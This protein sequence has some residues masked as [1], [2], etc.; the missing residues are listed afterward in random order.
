MQPPRRRTRTYL[1]AGLGFLVVQWGVLARLT[2]W[3]L[4]W[5][6]IEPITYFLG[7]ATT[8]LF[9]C[10]FMVCHPT[11]NFCVGCASDH[12]S[13]WVTDGLRPDMQ[14]DFKCTA[15]CVFVGPSLMQ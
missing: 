14:L 10:Y 2:F 15:A 1:W 6:V 13:T 7:S 12:T 3:E 5:D 9:Y 11:C 8:V 4:S